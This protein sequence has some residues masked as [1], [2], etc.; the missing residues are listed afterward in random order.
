MIAYNELF[1]PPALVLPVTISGV[2]NSRPRV[3]LQAIIDTGADVTAVPAY[4]EPKLYL[5]PV[6]RL[7]IEDMRGIMTQVYTYDVRLAIT[8]QSPKAMEVIF[9]SLDLVVL[10][11]DW[12]EDYYLL[13]NGPKRNFV[14]S[15]T[16]I[17]EIR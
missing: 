8:D 9:T 15:K 3:R 14:L 6:D 7:Q 11:R 5:Y 17:I 4:L 12:L 16:P 10:G 13:L 2:V 1:D